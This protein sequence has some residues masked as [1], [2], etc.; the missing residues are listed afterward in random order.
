MPTANVQVGVGDTNL[1]A[2]RGLCDVR[3]ISAPGGDF[4]ADLSYV[5]IFV[6]AHVVLGEAENTATPIHKISN[7]VRSIGKRVVLDP[8]QATARLDCS[9]IA[10]NPD[11]CEA[12]EGLVCYVRGPIDKRHALTDISSDDIPELCDGIRGALSPADNQYARDAV[13]HI[14]QYIF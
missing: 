12:C 13:R 5:G 3:A 1:R 9:S 2:S 14:I 10:C 8:C 6:F 4:T 11:N 7:V